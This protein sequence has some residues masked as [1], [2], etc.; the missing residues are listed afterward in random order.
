MHVYLLT[1]Y[2]MASP[3]GPIIPINS[4]ALKYVEIPLRIFLFMCLNVLQQ[5]IF[6]SV[7]SFESA[8]PGFKFRK[9]SYTHKEIQ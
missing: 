4:P 6:L 8:A 1:N 2:T 9:V 5:N 3:D 7:P